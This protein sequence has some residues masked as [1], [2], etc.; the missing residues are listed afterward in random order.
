MAI[1]GS[2]L[3]NVY[4]PTLEAEVVNSFQ[5]TA[6]INSIPAGT[7]DTAR[8]V[9]I[10]ALRCSPVYPVF[11]TEEIERAGMASVVRPL[12][13]FT[14]VPSTA[15]ANRDRFVLNGSDY[16]IRRVDS[17]PV[18]DPSYHVLYMEDE[19]L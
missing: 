9:K 18:S 1:G 19:G 13:V 12:K 8:T 2:A 15:I 11:R 16:R 4:H 6:V 5:L 17:Y 7:D 3:A 10:A 14:E